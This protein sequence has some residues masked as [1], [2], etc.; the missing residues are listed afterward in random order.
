[1]QPKT[2]KLVFKSELAPWFY[3]FIEEKHRLGY[4]YAGIDTLLMSFDKFL[5]D[6]D[7][8]NSLTEEIV[9][10]W[11]KQ[12]PHQKAETVRCNIR[13]MR[14]FADFLNRNGVPAYRVPQDAVPR[15]TYDFT[16]YIFTYDEI[17]R[18]IAVFD[19]F[20][21]NKATPKRYLVY[22]LLIRVLC[23]CGLRISEAL[24]LKVGD[25]DVENNY[26]TLRETKNCQ[27]RI[28]PLDDNLKYRFGTYK[29]L[30]DFLTDEEY[31]FPAPD[32]FR[33]SNSVIGLTFRNAMFSAGIPYRGKNK[34]PRLHDLRHT[35]CVHSMQK[36]TQGGKEAYAALPILMTYLGH[37]SID[38][39]SRYIHLSAESYPVL[40]KQTET[41]FA[42]LIPLEGVSD[43]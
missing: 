36:L 24:N 22:P 25:V 4:K 33:Y 38:A 17:A 31:F 10:Q 27:D 15:R 2:K 39:T 40:L 7:C 43:D 3:S 21:Y 34:G 5:F 20:K 28:I 37:K 23:F 19:N 32:G 16:P 18:I 14:V 41:L 8:K 42:E 13:T 12:K 26:F 11:V 29:S 35:F 30:M 1:M 9:M 6:K